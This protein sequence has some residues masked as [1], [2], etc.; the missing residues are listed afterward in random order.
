[1]Q[2]EVETAAQDVLAQIA[3]GAR[4]LKRFFKALVGDENFTVDVVVGEIHTHRIRRDRHAFD[5]DVRVVHEDVAVLEGAGLALVGVAAQVLGAGELTRHEA[6]LQARGEARAAA[7]AQARGLDGGD[8]LILRQLLP[9]ID[10]QYLAQRLVTI[11]RLVILQAP[12]PAIETGVDLRVDV[13]A[14]KTR[15]LPMRLET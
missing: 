8:D 13:A 6:P 9:A 4:L 2:L 10:A 11:A 5:D 14:V 15:F 3:R 7:P 12:V 1:M